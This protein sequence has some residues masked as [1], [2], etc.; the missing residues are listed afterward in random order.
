M[1]GITSPSRSDTGRP[2]RPEPAADPAGYRRRPGG[3]S[4]VDPAV[5]SRNGHAKL[6]T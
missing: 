6:F 5:G 4:A 2:P 1:P 3:T